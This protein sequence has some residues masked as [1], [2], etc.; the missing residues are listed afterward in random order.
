LLL[1]LEGTESDLGLVSV[2]ETIE[3][4]EEFREELREERGVKGDFGDR[5]ED[6]LLKRNNPASVGSF[7]SGDTRGLTIRDCTLLSPEIMLAKSQTSCFLYSNDAVF[8]NLTSQYKKTSLVFSTGRFS[9]V[10]S[11]SWACL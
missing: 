10:I 9:S 2:E 3:L 5:G 7:G 4:I 8:S 6:S 11:R 1:G